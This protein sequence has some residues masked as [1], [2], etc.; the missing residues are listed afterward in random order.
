M[1]VRTRRIFQRGSLDDSN[2][3]RERVWIKADWGHS[4][5]ARAPS[6]W[7]AD[8]QPVVN[9]ATNQATYNWLMV[10][11]EAQPPKRGPTDVRV[12]VRMDDPNETRLRCGLLVPG[13]PS[14]RFRGLRVSLREPVHL[15]NQVNSTGNHGQ[16]CEIMEYAHEE[17]LQFVLAEATDGVVVLAGA[18]SCKCINQA[19]NAGWQLYVS[20]MSRSEDA[21][22]VPG[23]YD[24]RTA[25]VGTVVSESHLVRF[26]YHRLASGG[27]LVAS[28]LVAL[29]LFVGHLLVETL[30]VYAQT[31]G[32]RTGERYLSRYAS[33]KERCG[34]TLPSQTQAQHAW[35]NETNAWRS[36]VQQLSGTG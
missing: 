10:D 30:N 19:S 18:G 7:L 33:R 36:I 32:K 28:G 24:P 31:L 35:N 26:Q 34:Q 9:R 11:S 21:R 15:Q 25:Q 20:A 1:G 23:L 6:S 14:R 17:P 8:Q 3:D 16:E 5:E 22:G 29:H 12:R 2:A 27:L 13:V 4:I